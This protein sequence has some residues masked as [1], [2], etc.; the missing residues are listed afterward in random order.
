[1]L[2]FRSSNASLL[3][4][5][6]AARAIAM[7]DTTD[8]ESRW[9]PYDEETYRFAL[10]AAQP[11]DVVIDIGAGDLRLALRMAPLVRRVY[12]VER[13]Q[14]LVFQATR[15]QAVP[16]NLVIVCSDALTLRLPEDVTLAVLLMRHCTRDHFVSYVQR[17]K[18]VGCQRLVTN[19]R[20]KMGVEIIDLR[21]Q[22]PYDPQRTGWY[23][24]HCGMVG[25][26]APD[27]D[28]ITLEALSDVADVAG[29]PH[30]MR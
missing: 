19:A 20:W 15:R 12:A 30:C 18:S 3:A 28:Q 14:A 17:L 23:A 5:R 29:C 22:R 21:C 27:I 6:V 16:G 25:F 11:D 8:W 4:L 26:N 13:N 9:A 24:C 1:M 10:E 2:S 7:A